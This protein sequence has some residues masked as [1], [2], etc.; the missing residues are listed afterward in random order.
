[1]PKTLS[2]LIMQQSMGKGGAYGVNSGNVPKIKQ[3][4]KTKFFIPIDKLND[5]NK[6]INYKE[7][8]ENELYKKLYEETAPKTPSYLREAQQY[9]PVQLEQFTSATG[10]KGFSPIIDPSTG[11]LASSNINLG[12]QNAPLQQRYQSEQIRL[13]RGNAPKKSKSLLNKK[14]LYELGIYDRPTIDILSSSRSSRSSRLPREL[15]RRSPIL[16]SVSSRSNP[17]LPSFFGSQQGS[18]DVEDLGYFETPDPSEYGD[19]GVFD[20]E[21]RRGRDARGQFGSRPPSIYSGAEEHKSYGS[22]Y[23]SDFSYA[24]VEGLNTLSYAQQARVSATPLSDA[25]VFGVS[26]LDIFGR[27]PMYSSAIDYEQ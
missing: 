26:G 21:G 3:M 22:E 7:R 20:V 19:S 1:M 4:K 2:D 14:S 5:I 24:P 16:S 12:Y 10:K 6:K 25:E 11:L 27:N 13:P 23:G 9:N 18:E 17:P 8:Y 15:P